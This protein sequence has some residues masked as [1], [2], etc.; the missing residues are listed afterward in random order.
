VLEGLPYDD[1]SVD[2]VRAHDFLEHIPIGQTIQ[3][4]TEI[5]RVLKP[6]GIFESMTPSTDGR[7]AFQDP[8]HVSFWNSNSWYYYSIKEYRDL[9]GI[10][11][12]FEIV[13]IDDIATSKDLR[14]IH[15]FVVARKRKGE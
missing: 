2:E 10:Q 4:V 9:Y 3:V 7:G 1:N 5:W 11:A 13:S 12:D 15:T 14:I 6:G 8:T